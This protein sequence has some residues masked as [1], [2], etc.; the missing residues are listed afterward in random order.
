[1]FQK[2]IFVVAAVLLVGCGSGLCPLGSAY[3]TNCPIAGSS[4]S[5]AIGVLDTSFGGTGIVTTPI[6]LLTD[7][8]YSLAQ[9]SDGKILLGGT[10]QV[11]AMAQFA[12]ARYHANGSLDTTFN[13]VGFVI[14]PMGV[15]NDLAL[16]ILVQSD[17]KILLGGSTTIGASDDFAIARYHSNGSLDTTFNTTGYLTTPIGGAGDMGCSLA[18][19]SD[20]K[21][22]LG[23][24]TWNGANNDFAIARYHSN[25]S[26]DTT[27]NGTGYVTT[28]IGASNDNGY[29][30]A[31]QPDGKILLGGF[32]IIGG[33]NDFAIARYHAN[34]S[35]DTTF[36]TTGFVTTAI[37]V[38]HDYGRSLALQPDG[39]ILLGGYAI[40][41]GLDD[42]AIARYHSNG[43]L[44]TTF[45]GTGRVTTPMGVSS[46]YGYSVALQPDGK[47]LLSGFVVV[48]E[49][50]M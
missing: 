49:V 19:Q 14:N 34:G 40:V 22:L 43:S 37:G 3:R 23:G 13:N 2:G 17:G 1:M 31:I 33:A 32:A 39:K 9:Q 18:Q 50:Q 16:S 38:S 44:D 25:G 12:M 28:A 47:I 4:W 48:G 10:A 11:G 45:N 7:Q 42:F 46:D 26:L 5:G 30:V 41:G 15:I 36:N 35:L 6:G 21:I 8:A 24:L 27:F 20:G 29:N